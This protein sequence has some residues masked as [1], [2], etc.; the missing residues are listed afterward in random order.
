LLLV[1]P[2]MIHALLHGPRRLKAVSVAW[3]GYLYL[4][5]LVVAWHPGSLAVPTP[6]FAANG[7]MVA[8]ALPPWRLRR[9][10]MRLLQSAFTLLLAWSIAC[11]GW[12]SV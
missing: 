9:R 8:F 11:G 5:A 7:F 12:A 10:G 6:L 3:S 4:A 2:A 1:L